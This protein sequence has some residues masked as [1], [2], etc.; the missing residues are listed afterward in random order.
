MACR[1]E[2]L[3]KLLSCDAFAVL[4]LIDGESALVSRRIE[5]TS[6]LE[7]VRASPILDKETVASRAP[8]LTDA[9]LL[10]CPV[11]LLV[12]FQQAHR[13]DPGKRGRVRTGA[14]S[15]T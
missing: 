3:F 6:T 4:S 10:S 11:S 12:V 8:E 7:G 5:E 2:M 1:A 14:G 13:G 9:V 15:T